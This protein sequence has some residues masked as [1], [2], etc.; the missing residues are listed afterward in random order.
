MPKQLI[1]VYLG[2]IIEQSSDGTETQKSKNISRII[3]VITFLITIVAA[4]WILRKMDRAKP[5]VMRQRRKARAMKEWELGKSGGPGYPNSSTAALTGNDTFNP[6]GSDEELAGYPI[7]GSHIPVPTSVQPQRWDQH[8]RAI[9][10]LYDP[11]QDYPR[12]REASGDQAGWDLPQDGSGTAYAPR[13]A[14]ANPSSQ[15]PRTQ[16]PQ[17]LQTP[18]GPPPSH[19]VPRYQ[20]TDGPAPSIVSEAPTYHTIPPPARPY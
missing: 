19:T 14:Y 3:L 6:E 15:S 20:L 7:H 17:S 16:S 2:V 8:G 1:T 4:W 13:P 18:T 11:P 9:P 5:E 10:L 12:Q